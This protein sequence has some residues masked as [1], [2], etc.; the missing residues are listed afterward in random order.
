MLIDPS[1]RIVATYDKIHMF[2]VDLP[3]GEVYRES[4]AFRHGG[5]AVVAETPWGRPRHDRLL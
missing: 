5:Q 1:G 3:N 2:D 4:D